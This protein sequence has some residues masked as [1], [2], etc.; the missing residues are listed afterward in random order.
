[1]C[2]FIMNLIYVMELFIIGRL[3]FD[4][5]NICA[6][7]IKNFK[8]KNYFKLIDKNLNFIYLNFSRDALIEFIT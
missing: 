4:K 2:T 3:T 8:V 1:M 5:T 7:A 6:V